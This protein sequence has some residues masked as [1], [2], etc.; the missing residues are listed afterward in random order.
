MIILQDAMEIRTTLP[1]EQ[2]VKVIVEWEV[3]QMEDLLSEITME[4]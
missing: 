1:A 4:D 2:N 3:V